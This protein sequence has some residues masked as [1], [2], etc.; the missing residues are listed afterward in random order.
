VNDQLE[1]DEYYMVWLLLSQ[2]RSAIFKVRHKKVGQYL[3]PNQAAA[4]VSVWALDGQ[5]TPAMLARRLFLEPHS[6]SELIIRMEKKGLVRKTRDSKRGNVVRI[7]ITDKGRDV[8]T[9]VMGQ[10]LIHKIVSVLSDEQ[11]TQLRSSLTLLYREALKEL[12]VEEGLTLPGELP[13]V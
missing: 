5:I 7:S 11:R 12:G 3:H 4:L 6:V 13:E 10:G 2:T 1:L 9:H 8:C